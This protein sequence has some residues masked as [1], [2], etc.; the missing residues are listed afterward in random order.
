MAKPIVS[1]RFLIHRLW[2]STLFNA[3]KCDLLMVSENGPLKESQAEISE[4]FKYGLR[5][6][7][8]LTEKFV[9][10]EVLKQRGTWR[11][12]VHSV[13]TI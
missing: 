13:V 9:I 7:H 4:N 10:C 3:V 12:S 8:R 11:R 1:E 5:S 6:F 2:F